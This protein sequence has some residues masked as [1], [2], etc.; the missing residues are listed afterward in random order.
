MGTQEFLKQTGF[1]P[2]VDGNCRIGNR[3]DFRAKAA[4]EIERRVE[5]FC[6]GVRRL[7]MR[8]SWPRDVTT[9][10]NA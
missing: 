1:A 8:Q 10:C 3:L 2:I 4:L 5:F 6:R 9:C 7:I